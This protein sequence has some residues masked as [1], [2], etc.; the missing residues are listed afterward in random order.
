[1]DKKKVGKSKMEKKE[2]PAM[3]AKNHP[4]K[5]LKKAEKLAEKKVS[6]KK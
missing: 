4:P 2:T 6:K 3:E 5:F 1:M